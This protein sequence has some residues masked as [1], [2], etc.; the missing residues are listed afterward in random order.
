[1]RRRVAV[2]ESRNVPGAAE[3]TRRGNAFAGAVAR[4]AC[5]EIR[6]RPAGRA[7]RGQEAQEAG[8]TGS[9]AAPHR[10]GGS[11]ETGSRGKT[12]RRPPI[13]DRAGANPEA[14]SIVREGAREISSGR[15]TVRGPEV[16]VLQQ[17]EK[18]MRR[19]HQFVHLVQAEG[20]TAAGRPKSKGVEDSGTLS[21][22][23]APQAPPRKRGLPPPGQRSAGTPG[24]EANHRRC[25][26][27]I[28]ESRV[29]RRTRRL[30][31]S[32]AWQLFNKT[33]PLVLRNERKRSAL[34]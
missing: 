24:S 28:Q 7:Q 13:G 1:M 15:K 10:G 25:S 9:L 8:G 5:E 11:G 3:T 32:V 33:G 26:S 22:E 14:H 18:A 19:L 4:G 27:H 16:F 23:L 29:A 21:R 17:G 34:H 6:C 31:Q 2:A 12:A 20:E 30:R